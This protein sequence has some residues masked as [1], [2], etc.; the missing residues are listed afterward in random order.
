[1]KRAWG[2]S[3]FYIEIILVLFFLGVS[4]T[5]AIQLFAGA[6]TSIQNS[7]RLNSA[8]LV[9]QTCAETALSAHTPNELQRLF[10]GDEIQVEPNA[11][12]AV[13]GY[14]RNW[15]STTDTPSYLAH[16]KV[17]FTQNAPGTAVTVTV[18]VSEYPTSSASTEL[19]SLS[20][21]HYYPTGQSG[22]SEVL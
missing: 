13:R 22:E 8:I 7:S 17:D 3:S 2:I 19:F 9:A 1:M 15:Q 16:T 10:L 6:H 12:V 18:T 21:F 11:A 14:D 20:A 5:A 4:A